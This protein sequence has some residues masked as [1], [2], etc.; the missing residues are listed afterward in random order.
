MAYL[1]YNA[2]YLCYRHRPS[3][4]HTEM[5]SQLSAMLPL[6]LADCL[7]LHCECQPLLQLGELLLRSNHIH[8][9]DSRYWSIYCELFRE[10]SAKFPICSGHPVNRRWGQANVELE[11]LLLKC[12]ENA[13]DDLDESASARGDG[14]PLFCEWNKS[15]KLPKYQRSIP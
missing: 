15:A 1:S 2:Y 8:S 10:P 4:F 3:G 9:C 11:Q 6:Q 7:H 12:D 14:F 13:N 5:S